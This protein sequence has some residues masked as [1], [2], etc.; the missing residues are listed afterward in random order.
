VYGLH[1]AI[2]ACNPV[3]QRTHSWIDIG[4]AELPP[5]ETG[6]TFNRLI[7]RLTHIYICRRWCND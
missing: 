7:F 3:P 1:P 5:S 6:L 2:P 4:K